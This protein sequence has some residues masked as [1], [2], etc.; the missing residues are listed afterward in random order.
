M[1][2]NFVMEVLTVAEDN[3]E[4]S[5]NT[6]AAI[7]RRRNRPD[8]ANFGAELAQPGDNSRYLRLAMASL[9]L[10]PISDAAQVE[11][12]IKDYFLFCADNDRK[13]SVIGMCNW[14]GISRD[15]V[16]SW[17]RG[18]YRDKT[19]SDLINKAYAMLEELMNDYML[20]GKVNPAS[21]IFLLKNIHGYRDQVD[22]VAAP[23]ASLAD[24]SA[25]D[26]AAKY[27]ELPE[28]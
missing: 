22:I 16:N 25:A 7:K 5:T 9:D 3:K 6:K 10:P 20:N 14:L 4:F 24:Q 18:E 21:G 27:A 19:H 11:R 17:R 28:D 15:T 1:V 26:V 13:P 23:A 12:R 2:N 8:L